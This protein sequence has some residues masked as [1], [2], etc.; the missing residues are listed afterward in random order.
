MFEELS[1]RAGE[2]NS[3]RMRWIEGLYENL[4]VALDFSTESRVV[5]APESCWV[6]NASPMRTTPPAHRTMQTPE[7]PEAFSTD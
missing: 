5:D 1:S 3:G 2:V 4:M 7:F 6:V